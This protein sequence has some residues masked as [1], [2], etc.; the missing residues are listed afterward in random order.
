MGTGGPNAGEVSHSFLS[1]LVLGVGGLVVCVAAWPS[2]SKNPTCVSRSTL[3]LSWTRHLECEPC[4][5]HSTKAD[6]AARNAVQLCTEQDP[7]LSETVLFVQLS[8]LGTTKRPREKRRLEGQA[9]V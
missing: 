5:P 1:G 6:R 9:G 2:T 7:S 8:Q 4:L 3:D